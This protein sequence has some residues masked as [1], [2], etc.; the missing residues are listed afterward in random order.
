MEVEF[1]IVGQGL[2]GTW[3]S[4]YLQ[5]ENKTFLVIDKN[6]ENTPSKISGG[7]INPVTGRRLVK[8]WLADE[9]LLL[10]GKPTRKSGSF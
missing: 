6:E 4:W 7:I 1:L 2:C 8:V 3:L 10:H 5:K 9:V